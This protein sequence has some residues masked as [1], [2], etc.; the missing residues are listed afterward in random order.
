MLRRE[1]S[2]K[3]PVHPPDLRRCQVHD[4]LVRS[5]DVPCPMI[6][7]GLR[8]LSHWLTITVR[9]RQRLSPPFL[10]DRPLLSMLGRPRD[11]QRSSYPRYRTR[12]THRDTTTHQMISQEKEAASTMHRIHQTIGWDFLTNKWSRTANRFRMPTRPT[13]IMV[14]PLMRTIGHKGKTHRLHT[15]TPRSLMIL[16]EDI[17]TNYLSLISGKL[18]SM[19]ADTTSN[20]PLTRNL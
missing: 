3:A 5:N 9:K 8:P 12:R 17:P 18:H 10:P 13:G 20:R 14:T 15:I 1:F 11:I 7:P 4:N 19:L 6:P 2:P 16:M